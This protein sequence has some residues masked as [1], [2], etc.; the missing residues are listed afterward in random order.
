[1]DDTMAIM[2]LS[3][4][5]RFFKISNVFLGIVP[6]RHNMQLLHTWCT[7]HRKW[8]FCIF[9]VPKAQYTPTTHLG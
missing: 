7:K 4:T 6:L 2:V 9:V 1:M 8:E 3:M 5:F